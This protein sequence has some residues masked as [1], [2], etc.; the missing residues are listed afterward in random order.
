MSDTLAE[1]I[2]EKAA[3]GM[4]HLTLYPVPS[5]D[6]KQT[7]WCARCTPSTEHRYS[8]AAAADPITAITQALQEMANAPK[9]KGADP[10]MMVGSEPVTATVTEEEVLPAEPA[11]QLD[12]EWSKVK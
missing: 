4:T 8:Q 2:R 10:K 11:H 7:Y 3:R 6:G 1:L 9:R 12:D 5:V